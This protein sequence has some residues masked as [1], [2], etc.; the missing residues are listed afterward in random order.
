MVL[1]SIPIAFCAVFQIGTDFLEEKIM[2][3]EE[4]VQ[5]VDIAGFN[6]I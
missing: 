6:K 1:D 4:F 2:A 5:S 3:F